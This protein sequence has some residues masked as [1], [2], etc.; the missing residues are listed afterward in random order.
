[1][2]HIFISYSRKDLELPDKLPQRIVT[3]LA[4][5]DLDTWVDWNS[6]PKGEDW[7]EHIKNGIEEADAF[8]FLVSPDSIVSEI[9]QKEIDHAVKNGKRILP[10]ILRDA[11]DIHPEISKRNWIFCR[12][13]QDDFNQ[14]I[15]EIHE[16]IQTDYEWLQY[17]RSLQVKAL[18]W[19]ATQDKSRLLRGKEL[20]EAEERLTE[21]H[22]HALPTE[23]QRNYVLNSRRNEDWIGRKN[24]I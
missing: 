13:G 14:A 1:M 4:E 11:K 3:A 22:D 23:L 20:T 5:N 15:A 7:W 17:H 9:C 10:V 2:S 6:I 12:D 8:L 16:T 24:I 18:A 21:T 19:Q